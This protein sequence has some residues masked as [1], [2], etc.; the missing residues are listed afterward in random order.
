[1][2]DETYTLLDAWHEASNRLWKGKKDEKESRLRL[3]MA[4]DVLGRDTPLVRIQK[5]DLERLV[6]HFENTIVKKT[7]RPYAPATINR[8]LAAASK[9]L[10]W[11]HDS[12][13]IDRM[14]KIP[15]CEDTAVK[16]VFLPQEK[17]PE[18]L[19]AVYS[20]RGHDV[21]VAIQALIITG[22]RVGELVTL[23]PDQLQR[24]VNGFYVLL[25]AEKTK[26]KKNRSV[27]IPEELFN[28]LRR[29]VRTEIP[30]YRVLYDTCE[31]VSE[32]L[33]LEPAITPHVLRH[34]F[35]TI[36]TQ[37]G[38]PSLTVA[39]LM[40]HASLATTRRYEHHAPTTNPLE[41]LH[42]NIGA[43]GVHLP[44]KPVVDHQKHWRYLRKRRKNN[45]LQICSPLRSHSATRP[46]MCNPLKTN[47]P[48]D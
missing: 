18:F 29:L 28:E 25:R 20:Y 33:N 1:M 42:M 43:M 4:I 22:M 23:G 14:P 44:E 31:M 30:S 45:N 19:E 36:L 8:V 35:G 41:S 15:W 16:D 6:E 17:I 24:S 26:T 39:K 3:M 13:I 46:S 12:F 48:E 5:R 9:L 47:D 27:P 38:V 21:A 10:R 7:G 11:A 32:A 40:G 37:T 34:T 2:A